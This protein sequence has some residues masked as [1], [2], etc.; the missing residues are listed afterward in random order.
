MK[1]IILTACMAF[2]LAAPASAQDPFSVLETLDIAVVNLYST[3]VSLV[4]ADSTGTAINLTNTINGLTTG[5]AAGTPGEPFAAAGV[6][7]SNTLLVQSTPV[8]DLLDTQGA[9]VA[10]LTRPLADAY[11]ANTSILAE[12]LIL[13]NGLVALGSADGGFQA[14][15]ANS[16]IPLL[17]DLFG[18]LPAFPGLSGPFS[19]AGL[20]G[21]EGTGGAAALPGLDALPLD[22]L[23]PAI[24]TDFLAGGIP[25][26]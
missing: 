17:S 11:V 16:Q 20:P 1:K 15:L 8:L 2:G 19:G 24:L 21:L 10:E 4:R 23:D 7:L 6:D 5:L 22:A 26:A 25:G 12:G 9:P 13:S 3:S 18:Q 14:L